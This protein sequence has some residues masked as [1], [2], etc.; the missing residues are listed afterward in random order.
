MIDFRIDTFLCV[1]KYMN[2]TKA[3]KELNITQP[4]VSQH[5]KYLENYYGNKLFTYNNKLL[6][7]TPAGIELKN[8]MLSMKHDT[9]RLREQI[10]TDA[11]RKITLRFGATLSI[12]DYVLPNMLIQYSKKNPKVQFD[13]RIANTKE[14]LSELDNGIIDFAFIEGNF[15][16]KEYEYLTLKNED[17]IAVSGLAFPKRN[18][19]GFADLLQYPLLIRESGSGTREILEYLLLEHGFTVSD[20]SQVFI[21]NSPQLIKKYLLNNLGISFLYDSVVTDELR[22]GQLVRMQIPD[23]EITH[24]FNFI[25]RKDSI[26]G[27]EYRKIFRELTNI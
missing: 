17:Y 7:M 4:G 3:S 20:F 26:Y 15:P 16:K 21:M 22:S 27:E 2:F 5:I 12:G 23:F 19:T 11:N 14:L 25:W 1:C 24:E 13:F 6:T 18:I 8:A 10:A 9:L